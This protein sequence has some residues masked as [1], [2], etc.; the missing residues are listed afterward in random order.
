[1]RTTMIASLLLSALSGLSPVAVAET[2]G[3]IVVWGGDAAV[4][5]VPTGTNFTSIAAGRW[6]GMAI[7]SDREI[8]GW[9]T[10]LF[11]SLDV[12]A[13]RFIAVSGGYGQ[14][15]ALREDHSLVAW[16]TNGSSGVP[17]GNDFEAIES[18][19]LHRLALRAD[20]TLEGWGFNSD[21]QATVPTG[22]NFVALAAGYYHSLALTSDGSLVGWGRN[23]QGQI[24]IPAGNDFIAVAAGDLHSLALKEDG[25]LVA[26]GSNSHGQAEVP[27][28]NNFAAIAA[29][30]YHN[31][32]LTHGGMVV[33]WGSNFK[34]QVDVPS[35]FTFTSIAAGRDHSIALVAGPRVGID[36]K[37]GSDPNSINPSLEGDLPV[38]ILGSDSF[39]VADV[40]VTTL[41]FGLDGASPD[42]SQGPHFE[43]LNGDVFTDLM[44]HFRIEETGIEFGDMEACVTG[45]TLD[46]APFEGCD[47][48]RTVPDMDGDALLDVEEA[49]I[50]TNPLNPDTD[51]DGFDDGEEVLLMGTD[52]LDPLDPRPTRVRG[53]KKPGRRHR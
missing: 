2:G 29:G 48:V 39:D 43:D 35:G 25:S 14:S 38:A 24:D 7:T 1:M 50:G 12:P 36:I 52:P 32:A 16:G 22:N 20:G 6:N 47:A 18:F 9:G 45:E 11:G 53:G 17:S 41:A 31:L 30:G 8:V 19:A 44:V 23:D 28:G 46:G 37:P 51:G 5:E 49:A 27:A 15:M 3:A 40:D 33:A 4:Q 13:G 26:W 21:G 34:G 42:H 10:N